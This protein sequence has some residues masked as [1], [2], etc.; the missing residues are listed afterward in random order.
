MDPTTQVFICGPSTYNDQPKDSFGVTKEQR[1]CP[2][3]YGALG[4][5][6]QVNPNATN[7][8]CL[9]DSDCNIG[10]DAGKC[11]PDQL[12]RKRDGGP[13]LSCLCNNPGQISNCPRQADGGGA[14]SECRYGPAIP[15]ICAVTVACDPNFNIFKDGGPPDFGC[16]L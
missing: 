8:Y 7:D 10:T 11:G 13:R 9:Q 6:P 5:K 12:D 4:L 1:G 16:G 15:N 14:T 2:A 3:G